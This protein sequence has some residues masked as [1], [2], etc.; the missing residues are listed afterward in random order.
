METKA[1]EWGPF[2]LHVQLNHSCGWTC[3][4]PSGR[5]GRNYGGAER[6]LR[7]SKTKRRKLLHRLAQ[8]SDSTKKKTQFV[9][10][11]NDSS[12]VHAP[13]V[14]GIQ[15]ITAWRPH[16]AGVPLERKGCMLLLGQRPFWWSE[17]QIGP[18]VA[19]ARCCFREPQVSQA[20]RGSQPSLRPVT[21]PCLAW[22]WRTGNFVYTAQCRWQDMGH[23]KGELQRHSNKH[24][25]PLQLRSS[26]GHF[27]WLFSPFPIS[28][29]ETL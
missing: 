14:V 28:N 22:V 24:I 4:T 13:C 8:I 25:A 12:D 9:H 3:H 18:S 6:A 17:Q 10:L 23:W 29:H 15:S 16:R 20:L 27:Q 21:L 1:L 19:C 7:V 11:E 5:R 26:Q 2:S